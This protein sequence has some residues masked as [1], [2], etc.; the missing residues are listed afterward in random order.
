MSPG[1]PPLDSDRWSRAVDIFER[2][3]ELALPE[4]ETLIAAET[5][6]DA[7]L[8]ATVR[9]MLAAG[10]TDGGLLDEGIG[11]VAA[12]LLESVPGS[13]PDLAPGDRVGSFEIIRELGRGGMGVVYAARDSVLGRTAALK[14]LPSRAREDAQHIERLIAEAKAASALDHPNIGT[15]YQLGETEDGRRFVVMALY[16]GETLRERLAR[17]SL[18]WR[19]ALRVSAR[20]AAALAAAHEIGIVHRDV[21]PANI[22]LTRKGEVKLVDFGV[23]GFVGDPFSTVARGTVLYISPQQAQGNPPAASDDVWSLGVVL[24]EMLAGAPPFVGRNRGEVLAGITGTALAPMVPAATRLPSGL[25]RVVS[26]ALSKNAV[27]RFADGAAMLAALER[28]ESSRTRRVA[29]LVAAALVLAASG[30]F[31]A[32]G[33]RERGPP[34]EPVLAVGTIL[35]GPGGGRPDLIQIL[36]NLLAERLA[37]VPTMRVVSAGRLSEV[38]TLLG[39]SGSERLAVAAERA[40]ATEMIEGT[41]FDL[42]DGRLRLELRRTDLKKGIGRGTFTVEG[43]DP[44]AMVENAVRRLTRTM[45]VVSQRG[46]GDF[47]TRSLVAFRFY[48]EGL[49]AFYQGDA[50]AAHRM[51]SEAFAEDS[52]FAMALHYD[53]QARQGAGLLTSDVDTMLPQLEELAGRRPERER[54]RILAMWADAVHPPNQLAIA[55]S[56]ATLYPLELEGLYFLAR[57]RVVSGDFLGGLP[58]LRRLIVLDSL[59]IR[60]GRAR[61]LA[62]EAYAE[63]IAIYNRTDSLAASERTAREWTRL[64]PEA[65]RAWWYL[66]SVLEYQDRYDEALAARAR[67]MPLQPGNRVDPVYPAMIAIRAGNWSRADALLT[68]RMRDGPPAVRDYAAS[69]RVTSLRSQGRMREALAL[70]RERGYRLAEAIVLTEMG[71]GAEAVAIF[72]SIAR[73]KPAGYPER[74][75]AGH[76]PRPWMLTHAATALF[77]AGDTTRLDSLARLIDAAARASSV[78]RDRRLVSYVR[79]LQW[80]ARGDHGRAEVAFRAAVHS[81]NNS[82]SRVNYELARTLLALGRPRDAIAIL[83]PSL[84]GGLDGG[85]YYLNRTEIHA[86]LGRAYDRAGESV[87]ALS[88]Y[89]RVVNT[90]ASA[91]PSYGKRRE[92]VRARF[93]AITASGP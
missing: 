28:C 37:Q 34:A 6:E 15:V 32:A 57:A 19:E 71:R 89:E 59:S 52:T 9:G 55:E 14:F 61:C 3:A 53:R 68:D 23:A 29:Q 8:A 30:L 80:S 56:L 49:R 36:P 86:L 38:R 92:A 70:A 62:C 11:A 18:P 1:Q 51:F 20:V 17:G 54:L 91:D 76:R 5:A 74:Y 82:Y 81:L 41:L 45:G 77:V 69:V 4:R 83:E 35:S 65:A 66:G 2:A 90:W 26:R 42:T 67:A 63:M 13:A 85:N 72:D 48:E 24:Y 84:R 58:P 12:A 79:G 40:G 10:A 64:Q 16:E 78:A 7:E 43:S 50:L 73:A 44:F 60:G 93:R 46:I 21:K 39:D 88:H 27:D 47:P 31:V 87:N 25:E 75:T 33:L 22:L